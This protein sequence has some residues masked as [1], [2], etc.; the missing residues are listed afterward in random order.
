MKTNKPTSVKTHLILTCFMMLLAINFNGQTVTLTLN[1]IPENILC[2]EI[3]TEQNLNM[4]L[5]ETT[6]DDCD[7]SESCYFGFMNQAFNSFPLWLYPSRLTIDLS[8]LQNVQMVEVDIY[9]NCGFYCTQAF[10]MENTE[11]ISSKGNSLSIESETLILENPTQEFLTELAISSCEG[12]INEIRIYQNT[13]SINNESSGV[14]KVL[15]TIDQLGR[16]VNHSNHKL[17]FYIYDDGSVEKKFV[18][19]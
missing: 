6:A 8:S 19:E 7:A 9:D 16:E 13:S 12:A 1:N 4:S 10:L 18:V 14:K 5:V 2:N 3:W 17:L 11:I 15:R